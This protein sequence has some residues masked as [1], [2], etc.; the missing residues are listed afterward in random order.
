[1]RYVPKSCRGQSGNSTHAKAAP[2]SDTATR[3]VRMMMIMG[4][5]LQV[6]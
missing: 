4:E 2:T 3:T 1:M 6:H 5:F